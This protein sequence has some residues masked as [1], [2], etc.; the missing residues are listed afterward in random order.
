M[1]TWEV[2]EE[3]LMLGTTQRSDCIGNGYNAHAYNARTQLIKRM[4]I[5]PQP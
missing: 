4:T 5:F 3:S 1:G 2:L